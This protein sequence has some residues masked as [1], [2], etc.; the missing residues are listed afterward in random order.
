MSA[1][2]HR[3]GIGQEIFFSH[4]PDPKFKRNLLSVHFIMPL[5][6][7]TASDNAV[8]PY[9]LRKGTRECPDFTAFNARLAE[10]YG[11]SLSAG[12]SKVNGWQI[13]SVSSQGLDSRFALENEDIA[14]ECASLLAAVVLD[15]KLSSAGLFDA[16]DVELERQFI[17]DTI[18]AEINDKRAYALST[19]MQA[20]C[21]GEPVAVRRYGD[22]ESAGKIAP[23]SATAAYRNIL[24]TATVEISFTGC[25]DPS[26]AKKI[27]TDAF[28][29]TPRDAKGFSLLPL[30]TT[31]DSVREIVEK[32][33]LSQSKLVMGFRC[34]ELV[35][36]EEVFAARMCAAILGGTPISKFFL[37]VREKLSLCYYC[38]ANFDQYNRLLMVD[39]GIEAANRKLTQE[40]ILRQLKAVQD[41]EITDEELQN[42]KLAVATSITRSTDSPSA[43]ESW[44]LYQAMKNRSRSPEE[45]V[46]E[47]NKVTK[48]QIV[49]AGRKISLDTIYFLTGK[50]EA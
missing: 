29:K 48:E 44:Y 45:E 46:A 43:M 16:K 31:A 13:I 3:V 14:G 8:V 26:S 38:A 42:T 10:L 11:A 30:R 37:N 41:G 33:E 15:P 35:S 2:L 9:I 50:E 4:I 19:C 24:K 34:G 32:M 40:E 20:M 7:A 6:A 49:A 5:D 39:S 18:E 1:A 12:V 25:G 21:G 27:F 17:L 23:A 28:A 36:D 22:L 47:L